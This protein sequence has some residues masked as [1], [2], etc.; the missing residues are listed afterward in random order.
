MSNLRMKAKD[1]KESEL[2]SFSAKSGER[3]SLHVMEDIAAALC[4]TPF[5]G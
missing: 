5:L 4:A 2:P 3:C 1:Y